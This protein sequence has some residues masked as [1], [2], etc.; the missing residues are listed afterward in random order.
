MKRRVGAL[1]MALVLVMTGFAAYAEEEN[2]EEV[3]VEE[4]VEEASAFEEEPA[5]G[6]TTVLFE[7]EPVSAVEEPAEVA[8]PEA[9]VPE[10]AQDAEEEVSPETEITAIEEFYNE[11]EPE[12]EMEE[13]IKTYEVSEVLSVSVEVPIGALPEN[14]QLYTQS[15]DT[16]NDEYEEVYSYVQEQ[17]ISEESNLEIADIYFTLDGEK[18]DPTEAVTVKIGLT[19][20]TNADRSSLKAWNYTDKIAGTFNAETQEVEFVTTN[21]QTF[22][23]TWEDGPDS[24]EENALEEN[25]EQGTE[26]NNENDDDLSGLSLEVSHR[27]AN[28]DDESYEAGTEIVFEIVVTNNGE[29]P[30]SDIEV[31]NNLTAPSD[32]ITILEADGDTET[33]EVPYTITTYDEKAGSVQMDVTVTGHYIVDTNPDNPEEKTVEISATDVIYFYGIMPL[34][35]PTGSNPELTVTME[36]SKDTPPKDGIAYQEGEDIIYEIK[37]KNTGD[38]P[39]AEIAFDD[40]LTE[41]S[42]N[43]VGLDP[44]KERTRYTSSYCITDDDVEH[45]SVINEVTATAKYYYDDGAFVFVENSV[46]KEVPTEIGPRMS[47]E[48]TITS[49]PQN[50]EAYQEGEKITYT[51]TVTNTGDVDLSNIKVTDNLTQKTWEIETLKVGKS[52]S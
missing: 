18:I 19:E 47:V 3:P 33:I 26:V 6:E 41:S 48:Y 22:A 24:S 40:V 10:E 17:G 43:I 49:T 9:T 32:P 30:I 8:E 51:I 4:S 35:V 46:E 39:L 45:G 5:E 2:P 12:T 44:D 31:T 16:E 11:E 7:E 14:A 38:V 15:L 28:E 37:V 52:K 20:F 36:V 1:L 27:I 25:D 50:G 21:L 13:N 29:F 23:A 34:D 42:W